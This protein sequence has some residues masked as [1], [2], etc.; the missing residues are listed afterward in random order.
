[1]VKFGP[2]ST[3]ISGPFVGS[4]GLMRGRVIV[5]TEMVLVRPHHSCPVGGL[6]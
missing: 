6:Q 2:L 1:M 4:V 3:A 5:L